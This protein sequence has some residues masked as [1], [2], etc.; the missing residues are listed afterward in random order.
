MSPYTLEK[1]LRLKDCVLPVLQTLFSPQ[2]WP[3]ITLGNTLMILQRSSSSHQTNP[4]SQCLPKA[5]LT[6]TLSQ[7]YDEILLSTVEMCYN[8]VTRFT[9]ES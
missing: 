8:C 4:D 6:V 5:C 9:N 7:F 2:I 3:M 1:V